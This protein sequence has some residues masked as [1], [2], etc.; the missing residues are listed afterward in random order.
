MYQFYHTI[1]H[2]S[3]LRSCDAA[4]RYARHDRMIEIESGLL[5]PKTSASWSNRILTRR[6]LVVSLLERFLQRL[7]F[8]HDFCRSCFTL[9]QLFVL[10]LLAFD[11]YRRKRNHA[12]APTHRISLKQ[13]RCSW[14]TDV[15]SVLYEFTR[16]SSIVV[17]SIVSR[18]RASF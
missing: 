10:L 1:H 11:L 8:L 18:F 15:R 7:P 4:S 14:L 13:T 5:L 9:H 2:L 6:I 16:S 17:R 3:D 12:N